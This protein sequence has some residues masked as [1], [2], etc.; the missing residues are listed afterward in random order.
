MNTHDYLPDFS[1]IQ[2]HQDPHITPH[3]FLSFSPHSRIF[4][5]GLCHHCHDLLP[6]SPAALIKG[7]T[8][9]PF[10]SSSLPR[11][12]SSPLPFISSNFDFSP[13]R[14]QAPPLLIASH[15]VKLCCRGPHYRL[16]CAMFDIMRVPPSSKHQQ[17][18]VAASPNDSPSPSSSP[19]TTARLGDD[20]KSMMLPAPLSIRCT[21]HYPLPRHHSLEP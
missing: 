20:P 18:T 4:S 19:A 9:C 5:L 6:P 2:C 17:S 14:L 3:A 21:P 7:S 8:G 15:H 12:P 1:H 16:R 10:S 13:H 11:N